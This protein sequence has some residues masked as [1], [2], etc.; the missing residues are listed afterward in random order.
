MRVISYSL[1]FLAI[2]RMKFLNNLF[3]LTFCNILL[4]VVTA[5]L[6]CEQD[7]E[8]VKEKRLGAIRNQILSKL[9]MTEAPKNPTKTR[10]LTPDILEAY[11][12]I[13]EA[14]EREAIARATGCVDNNYFARKVSLFVP[15]AVDVT[16]GK[17]LLSSYC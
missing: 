17:S 16:T 1:E 6:T 13:K 8:V 4:H 12:V 10:V 3:V 7:L 9:N 11:Q 15:E 5:N 14:F 2:V